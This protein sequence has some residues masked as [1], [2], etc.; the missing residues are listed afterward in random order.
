MF[1]RIYSRFRIN[2][3]FAEF[4]NVVS[5]NM[6]SFIFMLKKIFMRSFFDDVI[7]YR[8]SRRFEFEKNLFFVQFDVRVNIMYKRKTQK[9]I[10]VDICLT[11]DFMFKKNQLKN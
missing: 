10:F 1:N 11:D 2:Q 6:T 3:N 5:K 8:L 7:I 9:I 4:I